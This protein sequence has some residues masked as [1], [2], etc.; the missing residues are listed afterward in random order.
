MA[1][2][3]G[4]NLRTMVAAITLAISL[5]LSLGADAQAQN[6]AG[7]ALPAEDVQ[8]LEQ[9]QNAL[10]A[11]DRNSNT[12]VVT[13]T[14]YV[15]RHLAQYVEPGAVRVD[16]QGGDALAFRNP[17]G[18]VVTVLFNSGQQASNTTLAVAGTTLQ[19]SIPARGWATVNWQ[20]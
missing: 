13:P 6:A 10:L 20:G 3:S 9:A 18:S 19:F 8:L 17:D 15:F 14:Y 4:R 1:M 16:V 5:S 11:V 2:L 12:L 7:G